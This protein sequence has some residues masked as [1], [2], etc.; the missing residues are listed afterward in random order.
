MF[1][2]TKRAGEGQGQG[3]GG[4]NRSYD[5]APSGSYGGGSRDYGSQ[6]G[7]YQ[8]QSGYGNQGSYGGSSYA[9]QGGS[10]FAD[11]SDDDGDLP[12]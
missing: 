7:S 11:L 4:Y 12:F 5:S 3:Q 9:N 10:D 6:G 2:E 1:G 8:N